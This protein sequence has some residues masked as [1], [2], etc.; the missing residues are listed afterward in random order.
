VSNSFEKACC[1]GCYCFGVNFCVLREADI[2]PHGFFSEVA[3]SHVA[4]YPFFRENL[5]DLKGH[6]CITN[7]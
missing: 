6:V 7:Y 2:T 4:P 3:D 1:N 5:S